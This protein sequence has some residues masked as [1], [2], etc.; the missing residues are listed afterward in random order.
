MKKT[1]K[2]IMKKIPVEPNTTIQLSSEHFSMW[3]RESNPEV[4]L[5]MC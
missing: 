1:I 4:S 5:K 2:N 3:I